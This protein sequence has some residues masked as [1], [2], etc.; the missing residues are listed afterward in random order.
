VRYLILGL[1][2]VA[3]AAPVQAQT[4]GQAGG[5]APALVVQAR[6]SADGS[7]LAYARARLV[8]ARRVAAADATGRATLPSPAAPDTLVVAALGYSPW[9]RAVAAGETGEVLVRLVP[10]A[11]ELTEMVVTTMGRREA[12]GAELTTATTTVDRREISAQAATAV[13][14][15][16]A[17]LPGVQ[18]GGGVP[19]G[20]Q[21][22]IRGLGASRVLLLVD[23]EP[24]G[25]P[26]LENR[27]LSRTSTL[28]VERIEVTKGPGSVQHGSD[29]IGGVINVVTAAPEGPFRM[30]GEARAGTGGRREGNVSLV[31]GGRVGFRLTGGW[32]QVDRV[33]GL[34]VEGSAFERVWD[35]KGTARTLVGS[36]ALRFDAAYDRTRQRWPSA[37]NF[38]AFVD[39]WG[40][41]ALAEATFGGLG[42]TLRSRVAGSWFEYRYR[43][44]RGSTPIAGSGRPAQTEGTVRGLV[45]W[46]RPIGNHLLDVGVEGMVRDVD[47][48]ERITAGGASD[49]EL[50]VFAQ[51]GWQLG[52]L[53]L[54]G[55][56]RLSTNSRWGTAVTPSVGFAWSA[57]PTFR[58]RG[59]VARGYRAPSFK[60][61]AWDFSNPQG[62]YLVVGN[63]DL[64]PESSWSFSTG[65]HWAPGSGW[66]L[67][68]D[69]YR[70]S[71]QDLIDFRTAGSDPNGLLIF[72][73][74]NIRRARTQ[75][76][77]AE[78]QKT[79]NQWAFAVGYDYLHAR[80]LATDLPL[81]RRASH[82][83]RLR[84]TRFLGFLTDGTLDLTARYT[85]RA[86]IVTS[87][88]AGEEE[89]SGHQEEFLAIDLQLAG[90][91]M[92]GLGVQV[93]VDNLFDARPDD[94]PGQIERRVY[95]GVRAE[96]VP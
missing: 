37:G 65:F 76:I 62:G 49:E 70:N 10:E 82:T 19:A 30:M 57:T 90:K 42:G 71:I 44:A 83:G 40:T 8:V 47:A 46:T 33:S 85:G 16:V 17:E 78:L 11:M 54:N 31:S 63:P 67:G 7:V 18:Q 58:W 89:L 32:R 93:G 38:N 72:T 1:A 22:F 60:E 5:P 73:P 79:M 39:T 80:N 43:E 55:G 77:E 56:A 92:N 20:S 41:N 87:T 91:L 88:L 94:W 3:G 84:A 36:T 64:Q 12:R 66:R 81:D 68:A 35:V 26:L 14:Q 27:D 53:Y 4:P 15:V 95:L 29:A 51:D 23:G 34:G 21:L 6:D 45:A 61:L 52:S 69:V 25:G 13:D 59:S 96:V 86:P 24:V 28:A 2:L 74:D 48:P 50:D 75:G 9:R